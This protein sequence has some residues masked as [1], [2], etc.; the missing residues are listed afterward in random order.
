M[1]K[2]AIK[3]CLILMMTISLFGCSSSKSGDEV[4]QI[5]TDNGYVVSFG[6]SDE[7]Y[8]IALNKE[9][10]GWIY[11][12]DNE[13]LLYYKSEIAS[14]GTLTLNTKTNTSFDIYTMTEKTVDDQNKLDSLIKDYK[15][16]LKSLKLNENEL[17]NALKTNLNDDLN[18]YLTTSIGKLTMMFRSYEDDIKNL[19]ED[20]VTK[21]LKY[22]T[23]D[24]SLTYKDIEEKYYLNDNGFDSML[25]QSIERMKAGTKALGYTMKNFTTKEVDGTIIYLYSLY[26]SSNDTN[27]KIAFMYDK[28]IEY[29]RNVVFELDEN[30]KTDLSTSDLLGLCSGIIFATT[31]DTTS[32]SSVIVN[33]VLKSY[34]SI[35]EHNGWHYKLETD[36]TVSFYAIHK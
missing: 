5:L 32:D 2:K 21:Y 26:K 23:E 22:A 20:Q 34:S 6:K 10:S 4:K 33:K 31:N 28:N 14:P 25:T 7:S 30:E 8:T 35:V 1:L 11:L 3:L 13:I 29:T 36:D 24:T 9:Q 19:T 15:E 18:N 12:V 27:F 16:T 17:L